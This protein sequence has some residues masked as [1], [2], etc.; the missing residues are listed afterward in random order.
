[1]KQFFNGIF[2]SFYGKDGYLSLSKVMAFAGYMTFL[3]VSV[4]ILKVSPEKFDYTT[5]S[6]LAAG[7]S[8]GI[9]VLDKHYNCKGSNND[10]QSASL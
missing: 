3:I 2:G 7:S 6:I 9:R 8:A 4:I 10:G 1:M 5:F